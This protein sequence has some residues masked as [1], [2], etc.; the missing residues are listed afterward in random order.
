MMSA[1][2]QTFNLSEI[3]VFLA[4]PETIESEVFESTLD[5]QTTPVDATFDNTTPHTENFL[6]SLKASLPWLA[7]Y[8]VGDTD[9]ISIPKGASIKSQCSTFIY[10]FLAHHF[11][12]IQIRN[13]RNSNR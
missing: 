3:F 6:D 7:K 11:R 12:Y 5:Y 9:T 10:Y 4:A 1:S 13:K 2:L 8:I